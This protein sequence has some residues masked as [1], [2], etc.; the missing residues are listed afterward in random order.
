MDR[1]KQ[2]IHEIHRRSLWQVLGIYVVGGWLVFEVVQTLTEGLGLPGW[3]PA[4]AM[5]LLLIGLPVVMA[6]AFVQEGGPGASLADSRLIDASGRAIEQRRTASHSAGGAY[7]LFT[8]RNAIAG[9]VLAFALWGV[10][11]AGWLVLRDRPV[12]AA[13]PSASARPSLAVLPFQNLSPDP[14]NAYFAAGIHEE[15]LTQLSRISGIKLISRTSVLRYEGSTKS[16]SEIAAELGVS[17]VLE[18]SVQRSGDE[19]RITTQ[20]IDAASDEHIWADRYDRQIS[21]IFQI[22]TDVA[23]R[24]VEELRG[25]L[26]PQERAGLARRPTED[27]E[28]YAHYLR[29]HEHFRRLWSREDTR[30]AAEAYQRA[31][32][33]DPSFAGAW[34]RLVQT[35]LWLSWN[36]G[37]Y[38]ERARAASALDRLEEVA[39]ASPELGLARGLWLYYGVQRYE[40]ALR[41]FDALA[42]KWPGDVDV[43][44]Y[45][46]AL[47]RRLGRWD[48]AVRA[49]E[50][51]LELDPADASFATT[52]GSTY[53]MMRRFESAERYARLSVSLD[54]TVP[55][56]WGN[57]MGTRRDRGDTAAARMALESAA[58]V[59][60]AGPLTF[61]RAQ[62]FLLTD[63]DHEAL[64]LFRQL[65]REGNMRRPMR[66]IWAA[67]AA[68][69]SDLAEVWADT[70]RMDAEKG[71]ART[72]D[73]DPAERSSLLSD[74]AFAHAFLGHEEDAVRF[75]DEAVDILP[76]SR[77]A[78][79]G[80][81]ALVTQA[82]VFALVGR[83]DEAVERLRYLLSIP[84]EDVTVPLLRMDPAWDRLRDHPG[85]QALLEQDEEAATSGS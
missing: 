21:D 18:G 55:A 34:A 58:E 25:V 32:D 79:Y 3:F 17:T 61:V 75:A 29:G 62:L 28:A 44:G 68:G 46:G 59:L 71:L 20:L 54:P 78:F 82:Q 36:Y 5:L 9:G 31:V 72:P 42:E 40:D 66:M 39:P 2:L 50:R 53:R 12:R 73:D 84:A 81:R 76:V 7:G 19:V 22:Q 6:T 16:L 37:E 77:D 24:I 14:E 60:G 65:R 80:P 4:L 10:V 69:R 38:G 63:R 33:L 26:T 41:E 64:E 70:L 27:L 51:V 56:H 30:A 47:Y 1:L 23:T 43:L 15:L 57:L 8:W 83:D 52:I 45:Q 49:M 74:L 48:E 13:D 85:F 11:A 67:D 35:R